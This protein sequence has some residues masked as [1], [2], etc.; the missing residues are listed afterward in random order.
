MWTWERSLKLNR[1]F[2]GQGVKEAKLWSLGSAWEKTDDLHLNLEQRM[3][4]LFLQAE[5]GALNPQQ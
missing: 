2:G 3:L 5:I 1:I 4:L